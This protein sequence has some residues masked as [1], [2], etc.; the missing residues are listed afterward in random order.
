MFLRPEK[1]VEY[2]DVHHGMKVSDFGSGIGTFTLPLAKRV[3]IHGRVY[4]IDAQKELL[5][6]LHK[7]A[8]LH[9]LENIEVILADFE[10][11]KGTKLKDESIDR[12]FLVNTFFQVENKD[13]CILEIRRIL[14]KG[15]KVI[16]IDWSDSF[17]GV[18]PH[19][20][21]VV[22]P[23]QSI[24]IFEKNY[25]KKSVDFPAGDHHYGILFIK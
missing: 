2:C 4:A 15:G 12:V 20:T 6:K 19:K 23:Q 5:A 11:E 13:A 1:I 7:E 18:G 25:F 3:G 16:F 24:E 9:K 17:E 8:K 10:R 14:K 22:T 21:S